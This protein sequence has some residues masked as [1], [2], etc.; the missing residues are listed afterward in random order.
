MPQILSESRK[1][2]KPLLS[3]GYSLMVTNNKLLEAFKR[4][5]YFAQKAYCLHL[6]EDKLT[7]GIYG[8]P[9]YAQVTTIQSEMILYFQAKFMTK[10]EWSQR[11]NSYAYLN[12]NE[13]FGKVDAK[14][15]IDFINVWIKIYDKM[16][17]FVKQS[18]KISVVGHGS[19]G[20]WA[21][22]AALKLK[23]Y[24]KLSKE[25]ISVY[26]YGAPRMG[27]RTF[28]KYLKKQSLVIYRITNHD[29]YVP[30]FPARTGE[31][32]YLHHE[33]E[34]WIS[35]SCD[36]YTMDVFECHGQ[37][38]GDKENGYRDESE[39]CSSLITN[40]RG[41]AELT[42]FGPYFSYMMICPALEEKED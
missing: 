39:E 3:S 11:E 41:E 10:W 5:A 21:V 20:V 13:E 14:F 4:Y 40:V 15:Y 24:E 32:G 35:P 37:W 28:A 31:T 34:Y 22:L 42:H 29:D 30:Q 12:N 17:A 38:I 2:S 33:T 23:E 9:V 16:R 26:T 1:S 19:A 8:G 7:D 18:N 6:P 36:C 27:D 25:N